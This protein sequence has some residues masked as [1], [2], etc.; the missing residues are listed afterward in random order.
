MMP[1]ALEKGPVGAIPIWKD[2]EKQ[3]KK[4]GSEQPVDSEAVQDAEAKIAEQLDDAEL[5]AL[6][7]LTPEQRADVIDELSRKAFI[8]M[9]AGEIKEAMQHLDRIKR[10]GAAFQ[11]LDEAQNPNKVRQRRPDPD[12]RRETS[13][14]YDAEG[15]DGVVRKM[16]EELHVDDLRGIFAGKLATFIGG[17]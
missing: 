8:L 1:V 14:F 10:I 7:K 3:E 17:F 12:K 16:R 2:K 15:E 11:R 4:S 6:V 5:Q 13:S 9:E